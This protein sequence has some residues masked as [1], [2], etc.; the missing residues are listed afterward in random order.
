VALQLA[1]L[2]LEDVGYCHSER[3]V[4]GSRWH[5]QARNQ[6]D[7]RLVVGDVLSCELSGVFG[8]DI[9][10]VDGADGYEDNR[11]FAESDLDEIALQFLLNRYESLSTPLDSVHFIH[12]HYQLMN[13]ERLDDIRVLFC[14]PSPDKG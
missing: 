7:E 1:I 12:R 6:L 8:G 9:D 3:F 5:F 14:L 4:D 2:R 13:S 11:L 10:G